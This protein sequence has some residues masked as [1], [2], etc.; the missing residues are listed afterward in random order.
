MLGFLRDPDECNGLLI[1]AHGNL[2][3]ILLPTLRSGETILP[4]NDEL[5]T[6]SLSRFQH[7]MIS[8]SS[9]AKGKPVLLL[10][11]SL[12]LEVDEGV[13]CGQL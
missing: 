11:A 6:R 7:S 5:L 10:V 9:D 12:R 3:C 8:A 13:V 1:I 2:C 4:R